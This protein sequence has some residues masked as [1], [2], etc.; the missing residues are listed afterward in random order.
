[1]A[2]G[3]VGAIAGALVALLWASLDSGLVNPGGAPPG[4]SASLG[5]LAVLFG[6]S[7]GV[8]Q[9]GGRPERAPFLAGLSIG[10][11]TYAILRLTLPD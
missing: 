6:V 8:M 9:L 1:M 7:A 11:A 10:A 4:A 3:R 5:V 2:W